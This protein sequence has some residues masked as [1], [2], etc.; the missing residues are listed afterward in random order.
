MRKWVEIS[1]VQWSSLSHGSGPGGFL[2]LL[3]EILESETF[4]A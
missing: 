1:E 2:K 3:P 4:A